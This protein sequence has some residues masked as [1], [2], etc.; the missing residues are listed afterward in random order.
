MFYLIN[1]TRGVIV[2]KFINSAR[3]ETASFVLILRSRTFWSST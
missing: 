1:T 3:T 2:R